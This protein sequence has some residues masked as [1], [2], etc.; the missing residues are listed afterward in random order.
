MKNLFQGQVMLRPYYPTVAVSV[1]VTL[2]GGVDPTEVLTLI[3]NLSPDTDVIGDANVYEANVVLELSVND[4]PLTS[5]P[6]LTRTKLIFVDGADVAQATDIDEIDVFSVI[7]RSA[8][9][10]F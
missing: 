2:V 7:G 5:D 1:N 3:W 9:Y 4:V 8:S 6:F 10:V